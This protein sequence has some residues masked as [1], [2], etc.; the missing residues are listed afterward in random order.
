[1]AVAHLVDGAAEMRR[2]RDIRRARANA[3]R[4]MGFVLEHVEGRRRRCAFPITPPVSAASST[5]APREVLMRKAEGF[6]SAISR[7]PIMCR[8]A[9]VSWGCSETKSDSASKRRAARSVA[10][11]RALVGLIHGARPAIEDAHGKSPRP[12]RHRLTD[13][14]AAADE[15]D[16]FAVNAGAEQVIRLRAR[17]DP[18]P[19]PRGR[20][21][22]RGARP[23]AA[24]RNGCRRSIRP[25]APAPPSPECA[26]RSPP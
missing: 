17:K 8:V 5:T 15:A 20:L 1:M 22:R 12:R 16:G 25:R 6:I 19:A 11:S 4:H 23:R 26:A 10:S 9:G 3:G 21:R 18:R 14:A 2:Q 7:A 13:A 24:G